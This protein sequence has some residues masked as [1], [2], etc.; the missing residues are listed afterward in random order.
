MESKEL[1]RPG[2]H[3]P[4][5]EW[6]DWARAAAEAG[7]WQAALERW[8]ASIAKFGAHGAWEAKRGIALLELG[9]LDEAKRVFRTL[10]QEEPDDPAAFAGLVRVA[11]RRQDWEGALAHLT[12]YRK[13]HPDAGTGMLASVLTRLGHANE[14]KELWSRLVSQH[15]DNEHFRLMGLRA[16]IEVAR[17]TGFAAGE[18]EHFLEQIECVV[19]SADDAANIIQTVGLFEMAGERS[20]ARELL[21]RAVEIVHSLDH[22]DNCFKAIPRLIELGVQDQLLDRL[23]ARIRS[24]WIDGK[25][26]APRALNIELRL[27]LALSRFGEFKKKFDAAAAT[28]SETPDLKLLKP[29][30]AR[31]GKPRHEIFEEPKIF[32]IGLT[33]TGTTSLTE[34]LSMLGIDSAHWSNPLTNK[35]ISDMDIYL[36]GAA[37]DTCISSRF[38]QLY[39]LYPNA[40]F[41]W[42]RRKSGSWLKSFQAHYAR[43][44]LAADIGQLRALYDGIDSPFG[45]P[46]AI[47]QFNIY[48]NSPSLGEAFRAHEK[49]IRH[50]FSRK[51]P[52]KLL[53]LD[54][55][56]GQGWP[57][58]CGFLD[59]PIPDRAF[60]WVNR[61]PRSIA[62][63]TADSCTA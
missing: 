1:D 44:H 19:S 23:L 12:E 2:E 7:D 5:A 8:D 30:S 42:T 22:I 3:A 24:E 14:A 61:D 57:E 47:I 39:Y 13:S 48:L 60:P 49:R 59:R 56:S 58:L 21:L 62:P 46:S 35:P 26:L 27:L 25:P 6:A 37:G 33:K 54:L 38:E 55:F 9:R 41:I 4:R 15:P 28:L 51:P 16:S 50:F 32:V 11:M 53:E 10:E 31:L 18:R 29:V 63:L 45:F 17:R 20:R 52:G 36:F 43:Q 40:K 34:A